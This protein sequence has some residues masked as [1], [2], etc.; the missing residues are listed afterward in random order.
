MV[1]VVRIILLS[2][3]LVVVVLCCQTDDKVDSTYSLIQNKVFTPSCA[4]SGC[5]LS[6]SDIAFSEHG[7]VLREGESYD[8]LVGADPKNAN[9][10]SDGLQRVKP[11]KSAESLLY[12]KLHTSDHHSNSYGNPMPLGLELLSQGQVEFIRQW[13]DN[14]APREGSVAN[15]EFLSDKTPQV[16]P[17]E[18]LPLPSSGFQMKLEPFEVVPDFERE[19]FVYKGVGNT[20]EVFVNRFEIRMRLNSHHFILYDFSPVVPPSIVPALN[21]ERDIRNPDG[22]TNVQT[23]PAMLYH[24][25]VAGTQTPHLDLT[26]PPGVAI[27]LPPN[28]AF[29]M[30]SHYV[31]KQTVP[32]TGE[33]QVNLHT[34]PSAQ[35]IHTATA[36]NLPITSLTLPANQRT[37]LTKEF[38]M[39]ERTY[40]ISLTSHTHKLGEKF[41][42]KVKGGSRNGEIVYTNSDWHN[43]AWVPF[44]P[45][46]ELNVGEGLISEITYNNTTTRTVSFGLT[47]E[48]EMGIIFGY[49]YRD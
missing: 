2:A 6:N 18:S 12:H 1:R 33:V 14:G 9:A 13:I 25:F 16:D 11:F 49:Y 8:N 23:L 32:I 17:F 19:F 37:T 3:F 44:D 36:L 30:N 7:L 4:L 35:V 46:I 26:F 5:H 24:V 34:I 22:T 47:S 48:D 41:I 28:M 39:D 40:V 10:L 42:I 45:P 38:I 27:R 15:E 21:I 29:D 31:N 20:E 43:P